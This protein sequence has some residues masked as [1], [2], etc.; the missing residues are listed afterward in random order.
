MLWTVCPDRGDPADFTGVQAID[1]G[2][3]LRRG[4]HPA[5][6]QLIERVAT[7]I[8]TQ[9]DGQGFSS[10][11]QAASRGLSPVSVVTRPEISRERPGL[12]VFLIDQSQ[13]MGGRFLDTGY[14]KAQA[15][16]Y[17]VNQTIYNLI[18][19][20]MPYGEVEDYYH[21][22]AVGYG[23]SEAR[24]AWGGKLEGLQTIPAKKIAANPLRG[25]A[26]P[27]AADGDTYPVWIAPRNQ[28]MT[29]M[30]QA[31]SC[32]RELID[33]WTVD[34][35]QSPPPIVMNITDGEANDGDIEPVASALKQTGTDSGQTL[36]FNLCLTGRRETTK[37]YPASSEDLPGEYH[38]KLF[39]I[40]SELPFYM[41]KVANDLGV[42]TVPGSRGFVYNGDMISLVHF[43]TIGTMTANRR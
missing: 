29:P 33:D 13:S 9:S 2:L 34:F 40:T 38:R 41:A 7:M 16:A 27:D 17:T 20:C 43:L 42:E 8:N 6:W 11:F 4:A 24:L 3:D 23:G 28:G 32:A 30:C 12:F 15:V 26:A 21:F 18:L 39:D 19:N 31:L 14:S 36:L 37:T 22:A 1:G 5:T 35:R 25:E 10:A